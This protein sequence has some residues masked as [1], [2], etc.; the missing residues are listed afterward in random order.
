MIRAAL[1]LLLLATGC[2]AP[3]AGPAAR[4]G[5]TGEVRLTNASGQVIE[6]AY[7]GTPASWGADLLAPGTLAPGA[8]VTFRAATTASR[9]AVRV[10]F[11][12]GRA[13]ELPNLDLCETPEVTVERGAVRAAPRGRS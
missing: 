2:A 12:T 4:L 11:D 7:L 3:G 1:P 9:Q 5:C 10:V 6:Q 8:S 13:A